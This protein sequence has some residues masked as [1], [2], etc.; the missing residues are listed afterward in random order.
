MNIMHK[1]ECQNTEGKEIRI[2]AREGQLGAAFCLWMNNICKKQWLSGWKR[3][4]LRPKG[5]VLNWWRAGQ[6]GHIGKIQTTITFC[7]YQ[8]MLACEMLT[9][10]A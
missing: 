4:S 10:Y 6:I 7:L 9:A 3:W 8:A 1:N 5:M 2:R